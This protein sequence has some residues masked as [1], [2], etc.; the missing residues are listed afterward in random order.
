[1]TTIYLAKSFV[2]QTPNVDYVSVTGT[3]VTIEAL[4]GGVYKWSGGQFQDIRVI[5]FITDRDEVVS[6]VSLVIVG[7][8]PV[9]HP[10]RS[11]PNPSSSGARLEYRLRVPQKVAD[12][13]EEPGYS[14]TAEH[15]SVVSPG[16][17]P[18]PLR[19]TVQRKST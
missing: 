15:L 19:V 13:L 9:L 5:D 10:V 16:T 11:Y 17:P 6:E 4:P 12:G 18:Y 8:A 7:Y 2:Y 14:W 3:S 1:M